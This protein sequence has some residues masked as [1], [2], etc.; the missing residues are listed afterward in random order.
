M[1]EKTAVLLRTTTS[2]GER[3]VEALELL[4]AEEPL[5]IT[6]SAADLGAVREAV[7]ALRARAVETGYVGKGMVSAR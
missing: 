4:A 5:S 6:V 3:F 7:G 2:I 1:K